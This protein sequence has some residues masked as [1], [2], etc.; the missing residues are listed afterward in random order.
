MLGIISQI[1]APIGAVVSTWI[2]G[3]QKIAEAKVDREVKALTYEANWD[4]VQAEASKSSWKDEW[5]TI[6]IS[7]PLVLAF[8]P[9]MEVYIANGFAVLEAC[10]EWYRYL[11]GV[12]FAASF[13]Y[14]KATAL[15]GKK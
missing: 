14:K 6:I 15:F 3:K 9:G 2:N 1:V 7:I 11:V 5:L 13:G 8:M 12:V 10:P 4:V